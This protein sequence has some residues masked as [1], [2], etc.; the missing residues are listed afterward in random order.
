[1]AVN[2]GVRL[3]PGDVGS[4][5]TPNP[6]P[7]PGGNG[8]D[9]LTTLLG[10][11]Q[12][13]Q[14]G[15]GATPATPSAPVSGT[16]TTRSGSDPVYVATTAGKAAKAA[17]SPVEDR[18]AI[19]KGK[20]AGTPAT[21]ASDTFNTVDGALADFY[22]WDRAK[23]NKFRQLGAL[24]GLN[25]MNANDQQLYSSW[26]TL[27]S[28]SANYATAGRKVS[29]W[30]VLANSIPN[31]PLGIGTGKNGGG[32]GTGDFSNNAGMDLLNQADSKI[33]SAAQSKATAATTK[34]TTGSSSGTSTSVAGVNGGLTQKQLNVATSVDYTDPNVA[35]YVLNVA[36][37]T[38]LGRQATAEES[39]AF[40][41]KLT[42]DE[43]ANPK[44]AQSV[45]TPDPNNPNAAVASA[46]GN[47]AVSLDSNGNPVDAAGNIVTP[48]SAPAAQVNQQTGST[49]TTTV[50]Q[51][52]MLNQGREQE[53][54]DF[55]KSQPDYG[56]Y[57]AATTYMNAFMQA[58]GGP[59]GLK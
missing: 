22:T 32:G 7:A 23:L 53:A 58:I 59:P 5:T 45:F 9:A 31:N 26:Q 25:N 29:P 24:A 38:L 43:K 49:D 47:P 39:K 18:G 6:A 56:A 10:Q 44:V 2:S 57:Q 52:D 28:Q 54:Q 15:T 12:N 35:R 46:A 21:P 40:Y 13:G 51:S 17:K 4:G 50:N 42:A 11:A 55:A 36:E 41:A 19:A 27:V 1:M 48:N 14:S 20:V 30:D 8:S 37:S 3:A 16:I 34:S 33:A